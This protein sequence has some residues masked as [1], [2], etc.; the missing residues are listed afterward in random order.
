M[1]HRII[2]LLTAFILCFST[3]SAF[4]DTSVDTAMNLSTTA[5]APLAVIKAS[6]ALA[7]AQSMILL[8]N[9]GSK[10]EGAVMETCMV[11]PISVTSD[12]DIITM[13]IA[14]LHG[15]FSP[16]EVPTEKYDP[17]HMMAGCESW[18]RLQLLDNH[19]GTYSL[20]TYQE[21]DDGETL[22]RDVK[23]IFSVFAAIR[24]MISARDASFKDTYHEM[25]EEN[26]AAFCSRDTSDEETP[27][28]LEMNVTSADVRLNLT[29]L[30][31]PENYPVSNIREY[32]MADGT[33]YVWIVME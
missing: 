30:R 27:V 33:T 29:Y 24:L 1:K 15:V 10:R 26:W 17:H 4:A 13:E 7:A 12:D 32:T 2:A 5:D 31:E 8:F 9:A 18:V 22:Y 25:A 20:L 16:N 28:F 14:A 3:A 23:R 21:P 6:S 11:I 19:D